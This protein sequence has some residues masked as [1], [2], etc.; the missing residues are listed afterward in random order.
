MLKRLLACFV[1][2]TLLAACA[3]RN[4]ASLLPGGGVAPMSPAA[5]AISTGTVKITLLVPAIPGVHAHYVS[6]STKS[7][8]IKAHNA[9]YKKLPASK[10]FN[11]KAGTQSCKA[12]PGGILCTFELDVFAGKNRFDVTSYDR[13]KGKGKA[14]SLLTN[15]VRTVKAGKTLNLPLA[16][17]GIPHSVT[18]ERVDESVFATGDSAS[19]FR[20]AGLIPHTMQVT[21]LDA[22]GNIIVGK[23]APVVALGTSDFGI[24][25]VS[26]VSG[27]TNDFL[28]TPHADATS[29]TLTAVAR[30]TY[31][32]SHP[33]ILLAS[34]SIGSVLYVANYGTVTPGGNVT[35]YVPWSDAPIETIT[36]GMNNPAVMTL[37]GSGNLWV[38]NDAGGAAG[39]ATP[40]PGSIAEYAPGSTT[41]ART[42]TGVNDPS[43]GGGES[44]SV[45]KSGNLYCACNGA[46]EVDEY[47]AAGGST[48]SRS[49]TSTSSPT[50]ISSPYSVVTDSAGNVYVANYSSNTVGISVFGP[51][52]TTPTRNITDGVNGVWLL[53]FDKSG[54]LYGGN[55]TGTPGTITEYAPGGSTVVKTFGS[56]SGLYDVSA[57]AVDLSGNVY[58]S[59][60]NTTTTA[61]SEY[62]PTSLAS[63]ARSLASGG[64]TYAIATDP[65]GNVY[66]PG[67]GNNT[68]TVYPTGTSTTPSR[69]LTAANLIDDPYY[70]ATWP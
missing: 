12:T 51:T 25:S 24:A 34:L 58:G 4:S 19:G 35:A 45:D 33:V 70:V 14:L 59:S 56:S 52:G 11:V 38:G 32:G 53:A 44:L 46:S 63:P 2:L 3:A 50:G 30:G 66:I 21:P 17:I 68:V 42:I 57:L 36:S 9:K 28:L 67:A 40:P 47:T 23:G 61:N 8:T 5:D 7:I 6:P 22:D 20:F 15:F 31:K 18:L 54:N 39:P 26:S 10:T 16:L 60:Y 64:Y 13:P 41:P 27:S 55:Y 69:V 43:T 48:P 65:L 62:T 29:M 1:S 49:M 37:D